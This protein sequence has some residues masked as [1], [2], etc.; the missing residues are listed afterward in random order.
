M[1][2]I[3]VAKK[4]FYQEACCLGNLN[5][6]QGYDTWN[7]RNSLGLIKTKSKM[8]ETFDAHNV[9]SYCLA[10]MIVPG[11]L[12]NTSIFRIMPMQFHRRQLHVLQ[13]AKQGIRKQYGGTISMG[14][15]RG[16]IGIHNKL[17]IGY[18]GGSSKGTVSF[19]DLKT[20]KRTRQCCKKE[21]IRI[22]SYNNWKTQCLRDEELL[23]RKPYEN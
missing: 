14:I 15:K 2:I 3:E 4:W 12:D 11:I 17:G 13:P 5:I 21:D 9:D 22:L 8:S 10:D 6:K 18:I 1:K 20:G 7:H 19:Y 23:W 16:S